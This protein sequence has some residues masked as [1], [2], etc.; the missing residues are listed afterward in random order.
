M[1]KYRHIILYVSVFFCA[2]FLFVLLSSF[3]PGIN[4]IPETKDT[5]YI[6]DTVYYYDTTF[7]YDTVFLSDKYSDTI[8]IKINKLK[9]KEFLSA[10]SS[11]LFNK[12][13]NLIPSGRYLFSFDFFFSPMYSIHNFQSHLIYK[14]FSV[15]NQNSVQ[16]DLSISSGFGI[17]FH[18]PFLTYSSG[19]N[20]TKYRES[21]NFLATNYKIDTIT[22]YGYFTETRMQIDS[23]PL[24]NI[25][26]LLATG[27]TVYYWFRDTNYIET[28]DS[29]LVSKIDSVSF[30]VNDKASNSYSYIEIPLI[31][32]FNIYR[33]NY[34]FSPQFGIITSFFVNS[35]GK[36]VS[37]ANLDQSNSLKDET[38]F[39]AIN[40]SFYAG[41][42][43][44]YLLTRRLDFFTSAYFRKN[45]HSVYVDYPIVS[46]FN[47]F[48]FKFGLRYK[49][50]F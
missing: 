37:L 5:I 48:G 11:F 3:K 39:A 42:R 7:V 36:I 10:K 15:K 49:L 45:I 29:A 38:K 46:R 24:I 34:F 1:N 6:Y 21:F 31:L 43:F 44:N 47:T 16:E 32:S 9:E 35:K 40:L 28:L 26:T 14:E 33:T 8:K 22:A 20:F 23:I 25:D 12:T 50:T 4:K 27:D 13:S 30:Q 2:V 18:K 41:L 17:N 19:I